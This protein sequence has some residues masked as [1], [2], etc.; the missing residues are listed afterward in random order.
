VALVI[1]IGALDKVLPGSVGTNYNLPIYDYQR[2]LSANK[3]NRRSSII[4][5]W[6]AFLLEIKY[7]ES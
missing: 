3:K 6:D 2:T 4:L 5:V 1:T 7:D